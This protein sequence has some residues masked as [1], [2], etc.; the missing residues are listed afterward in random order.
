VCE[1]TAMNGQAT[2]TQ[3]YIARDGKQHGPLTDIEMRTFVAHSY[4]RPQDLIWRP[5]MAEWLPAPQV[6]P[7]VFQG[8]APAPVTAAPAAVPQPV[9]P[10]PTTLA[11]QGPSA[12][13]S[14]FDAADSADAKP[15]RGVGRQLATAAAVISVI[16]GGAFAFATYR[17]PIMKLV[18]GAPTAT[19]VETAVVAVLPPE[20]KPVETASTPA[21]P[22]VETPADAGSAKPV[23]AAAA[24][25]APEQKTAALTP[26]EPP[27]TPVVAEG[28][29]NIDG[30]QIDA[31]LQK[32]PVWALIKK[33]Y[34][35]WYVGHIS[36]A[37]KL[38]TDKRPESDVAMHLAQGLV[39]LRRQNSDKALAASPDKLRKIASAFLENLKSLQSQ[40]VSSCYGFISKGETSPAIVQMMQAPETATSFNANVTAIFEAIADGGKTPAKHAAA[41][42]GDYDI[43]IKE[44][45][46]IGWK[47]EDLQVFSNPKLLSKRPPEMVCKMVLDW[48]S[49]HLAVKDKG[50]QDRLLYET[51]KPVVSG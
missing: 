25:P 41:V 39:T 2:E 23:D 27:A 43:L 26:P 37:E 11:S 33:D 30:S 9:A 4:L 28:P 17:E 13:T 40:S 48:F 22:A 31:R 18:T 49:A 34:P 20:Q 44:L 6:F 7:A 47:E 1:E 29:P 19:K 12:H 38:V 3:W 36:A 15:R 45:G 10:A 35:D 46:K 14:D 5:G 24:T 21:T 8:A 51:L 42:K 50:V 16:G 32:I